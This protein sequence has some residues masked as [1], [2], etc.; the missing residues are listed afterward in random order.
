MLQKKVY[1]CG[2][3]EEKAKPWAVQAVHLIVEIN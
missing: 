1:F 3:F 2:R